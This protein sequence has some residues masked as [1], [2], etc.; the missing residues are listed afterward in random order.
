MSYEPAPQWVS[1]L[2]EQ[3]PTPCYVYSE[4]VAEDAIGRLARLLPPGA[5]I[6]YSLKANPQPELARF[7]DARGVYPEIA[8]E[9][10]FEMCLAGG[11]D[12]R[13]ILVGGVAKSAR[14]MERACRER[15]LAMTIDS[16]GELQR[17]GEVPRAAGAARLL[18]RVNP[19]IPI[20][21]L[22][23][24][25]DSQFGIG[26][27]E[28]IDLVRRAEFGHHAFLGLHFY[29]GSQRL[30]PEPV[31]RTVAIVTDVLRRFAAAGLPTGVVDVGLGCGVPYLEKDSE[32]DL[33]LVAAQLRPLWADPAWSGVQIWSE[34]GRSLAGRCG[35]FVARVLDRKT[36]NGRT[37]VMLDGG[38]N[39]HNPGVGLG[40]FFKANPRFQ[41][42]SGASSPRFTAVS[43]QLE[44]CGSLCTSSDRLGTGVPAPS[45]QVGDLVAIPNSGAYC[46][47]TAMLG[48]NSQPAFHEAFLSGD[49]VLRLVEPQ[50]RT[51]LAR[52]RG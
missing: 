18:L 39:A 46:Q 6:L 44:I 52:V 38:L 5:R 30:K 29:F 31:V 47:T 25:G 7:F 28:A 42:A 10:E 33:E 43:E 22:D 19:G 45:L 37:F 51:F 21:G 17:L 13:H 32:L 24:G 23:M 36:L 4:A 9:G 11:I 27:D 40:R 41:F 12:P 8:S 35:T 2:R 50:Y 20:G 34:A 48:F 1:D 15:C 49:G 14:Y 26:V 16:I 3:I